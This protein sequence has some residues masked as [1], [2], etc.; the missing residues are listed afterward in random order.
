MQYAITNSEG[1]A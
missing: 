1:I